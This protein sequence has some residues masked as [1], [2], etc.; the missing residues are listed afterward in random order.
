MKKEISAKRF[1]ISKPLLAGVIAA[2]TLI[3]V[4]TAVLLSVCRKDDLPSATDTTPIYE[5]TLSYE[6][7]RT[8]S[9]RQDVLYF[10]TTGET[11]S[12]IK[13][14]LYPN[15]FSE[16]AE[17]KPY[18]PEEKE[19]F[20]YNGESFGRIN[21]LS[22]KTDRSKAEFSI[23][24][25]GGQILEV[26]CKLNDGDSVTVSL[27]CEI[28]LPECRARFG[29]A[30]DS[31]NLTGFYPALCIYENGAW[32]EDVYCAVGDPFYSEI[33]S[34][35]VTL[36]KPTSMKVAASGTVTATSD[37]SVEIVAENVRDFGMC[38]SDKYS[39]LSADFLLNGKTVKVNYFSLSDQNAQETLALAVRA[40][41]TFSSAFGDYPY[42]AFTVAQAEMCA[43]GME[44]G[45]F[46]TVNPV[47]SSRAAYEQTVVHE[48]AHQWWFGAVGSDQINSPWLDEGLTEFSTAL[49][50]LLNGDEKTYDEIVSSSAEYYR[51]YQSLPAAIGFDPSMNRP[52]YGYVAAG[53]YVAVTYMKG[54]LL[55]D[56]LMT[57][58][59][60]DRFLSCMQAYYSANRFGIA[61]QENL[62]AVFST[63][64]LNLGGIIRGYTNGTAVI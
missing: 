13:F 60:K 40:V 31:V 35:Y 50:Y 54:L 33:A 9:L 24:G 14:H 16:S 46:V 21:V 48:T 49:F 34:F 23:Y 63:G 22:A 57:L 7:G 8:L 42:P 18:L 30:P 56:T 58:A 47:T 25:D 6:G 19:T 45:S 55:F 28:V 44:Y 61:T 32:R 10:N 51:R 15:A 3:V 12:E 37:A 36:N 62:E 1:R 26:P 27:E 43:G 29:I 17:N 53:E 41:E 2:I 59:G 52:L 64:N 39:L 4:L 11:L 38:L 20:F 5:M